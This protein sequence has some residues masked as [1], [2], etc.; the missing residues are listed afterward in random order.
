MTNQLQ[1]VLDEAVAAQDVP[2]AVG[3]VGNSG[4]ILFEG[5]AGNAADGRAADG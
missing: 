5:T 3:M 2:F 4:G 1:R